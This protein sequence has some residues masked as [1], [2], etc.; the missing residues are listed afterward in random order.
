MFNE[1][2]PEKNFITPVFYL[3]H[4]SSIKRKGFNLFENKNN[5][6]NN[7]LYEIIIVDDFS[8]IPIHRKILMKSLILIQK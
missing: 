1:R 2:I 4:I 7:Y 6:L 8:T 5:I 3:Q